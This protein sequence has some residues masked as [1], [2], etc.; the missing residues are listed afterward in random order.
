MNGASGA[1][2]L[3]A[4]G[5]ALAYNLWRFTWWRQSVLLAVNGYFLWTFSRAAPAA[6][7]PLLAFVGIGYVTALIVR[8]RGGWVFRAGLCLEV[9]LLVWLKRYT[10]L[11]SALLLRDTYVTV[12]LSYVCFRM[13]YVLIEAREHRLAY[14]NPIMY[15]NY[16]LNFLTLVSGPIQSFNNFAAQ[17][18][19]ASTAA[20]TIL[21]VGQGAERVV[22][23]LFKVIVLSSLLAGLQA[24][25]LTLAASVTHTGQRVLVAMLIIGAYPL[26]L[27]TNFSGYIDIALG[28]G[29][30]LHMRL[31]ENFDRPF[32]APNFIIFWSRWHMTL[33]NFFRSYVFNPL[34]LALL[35]RFPA[36]QIAPFLAVI[37]FFVTFFILGLW[38]GQSS[39]FVVYGLILALGVSVNKLYQVIAA[40]ILGVK[41]YQ[42][43]AAA[44]LYMALCRGLT[45][46]Y[47]SLS[48]LLFWS[49]WGQLAG[50][51][52]RL[53]A[54]A[55]TLAVIC[56]FVLA[57]LVLACAVAA[58]SWTRSHA[59]LLRSRYA[60]TALSSALACITCLVTA[61]VN[62]P[63]PENVY[64]AF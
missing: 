19:D 17:Q 6:L 11:P 59:V 52:Q 5:A 1:F 2:L 22:R 27:Y 3:L 10:F 9:A 4:L 26:Y 41:R 16:T 8:R 37:G 44:P 21:D 13:L 57:T 20:L 62:A 40:Q 7:V 14:L 53:G 63:A 48:L 55:L 49:T 51:W 25:G 58:G 31:P 38:H 23:G 35:R 54:G 39:E 32:L 64:K 50:L 61:I 12:G 56:L 36:K 29:R 18:R 33:S 34:L 28:F 15:L 46:T 45:F 60:R 42:A 24:S 47:F 30:Y 43:L